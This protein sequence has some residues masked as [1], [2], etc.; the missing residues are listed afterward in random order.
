MKILM[1]SPDHTNSTDG[2]IINGIHNLLKH[3]YGDYEFDYIEFDRNEVC[4]DEQLKCNEHYDLIVIAGTP[5]LWDL[6]NRSV[7]WKNLERCF[8]IHKKSKKL[9]MGIG[10]CFFPEMEYNNTCERQEEVDAFR[11]I[12]SQAVV[13]VR[14]SIAYNK[15][16]KAGIECTL[17]V[18]PSFFCYGIEPI[19]P[20]TKSEN[21]LIW[22]D[23]L[24][25][26]SRSG[27]SDTNKL[28]NYI[29]LN[30]DF[31]KKFNPTIYTHLECE[32]ELAV[33]IGLPEPKLI[34]GW[35]NTLSIMQNAN[36]VL[37]GRVHCSVPAFVQGKPVGLLQIDSRARVISDF[38]GTIITDINQYNNMGY[39]HRDFSLHL[40]KYVQIL[41]KILV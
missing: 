35:A 21:V 19:I 27:W 30:V 7:K 28:N 29:K 31:Y 9:F 25:G 24:M 4:T 8:E 16:K 18:C 41:N 2:V 6:F 32:K 17:L 15:L 34:G 40:D 36:F 12:Y 13:I 5:W 3:V 14:D 39:H 20:Q 26:L 10:S 33:K 22:Y 1:F 38:G 37:S 23:P 11:K